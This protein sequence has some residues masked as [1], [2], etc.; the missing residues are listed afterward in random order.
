MKNGD[1]SYT[2]KHPSQPW[3]LHKKRLHPP[4]RELNGY[5][6]QWVQGRKKPVVCP[7]QLIE[8]KNTIVVSKKNFG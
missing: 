8:N 3:R 6:L 2:I 4:A 7:S 5:Y 1:S